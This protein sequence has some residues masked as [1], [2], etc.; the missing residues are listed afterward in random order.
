[1]QQQAGGVVVFATGAAAGRAAAPRIR[2]M[3]GGAGGPVM[4]G[5][6]EVAAVVGGP[7]A[8]RVIEVDVGH[9]PREIVGQRT[10]AMIGGLHETRQEAGKSVV[11][12]VVV[13]RNSGSRFPV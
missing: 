5:V 8:R 4:L 3:G 7:I 2:A 12:V 1:M 6:P 13:R 11:L 10:P 9:M